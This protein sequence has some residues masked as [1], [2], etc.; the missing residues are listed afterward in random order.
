[1]RASVAKYLRSIFYAS[2]AA[3]A[4]APSIGAAAVFD[5]NS[6]ND[7]PDADVTDGACDTDLATP[8]L[9][10]SL[11]AAIE[12]SNAT[13]GADEIHFAVLT[14]PIA[15]PVTVQ[16]LSAL[17]A[18]TDP[19]DIDGY[20]QFGSSPATPAAPA[21]LNV[22]LDGS[23]VATGVCLSFETNDSRMRGLVVQNCSDVGVLV[24]G[25]RNKFR[26]NYIGTDETGSMAAPN[27]TGMLIGGIA[28]DGTPVGN[29][30]IIGGLEVA[31][32]NLISG[33]DEIGLHVDGADNI[34]RG[35]IIGSDP[36]TTIDLGNGGGASGSLNGGVVV[37]GPNNHI[38]GTAPGALN[39]IS[40]N[41]NGIYLRGN[42][43]GTEVLGNHIGTDLV[44]SSNSI[45][46]RNVDGVFIEGNGNRV[47]SDA[48][49]GGNVISNNVS[50]GI[51]IAGD[52][53]TVEGNYVGLDSTGAVAVPNI[54]SGIL[55][56]G[57]NNRIG[58]Q[59]DGARNVVSGNIGGGIVVSYFLDPLTTFTITPVGNV[60][61]GNYVGL[62][63]TGTLGLG[64][65]DDGILVFNGTMTVIG[66]Q[67]EN[68]G[69]VIADNGGDGVRIEKFGQ[70]IA[71]GNLLLGN[72][73][74]L[75][76]NSVAMGN[77]GSGVYIVGAS[78]N[79]IGG[80]SPGAG[81]TIA[82]NGGDGV[83]VASGVMNAILGNSIF[84]NDLMGIDLDANGTT[85]NDITDPDTGANNLQ[86]YPLLLSATN[87]GGVTAVSGELHSIPNTLVRIELFSSL[88]CDASNH[89]EGNVFLGAYTVTTDAFGDA[90]GA[91]NVSPQVATGSVITATATTLNGISD[92]FNTSEFSECVTVL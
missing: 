4:A 19:V 21:V 87:A 56:H 67:A 9:Q 50:N 12:Q 64:N 6:L 90:L 33:N 60:V 71:G 86:N 38:G 27:G 23:L 2:T 77:G 70:E 85:V 35:N 3:L 68:M 28:T 69:N 22:V 74:G 72:V 58:G 53:N 32:R 63:A 84:L 78:L 37:E 29:E 10:C 46:L 65:G 47:G 15:A 25:D 91:T 44:G 88:T 41:S 81:N 30:N 14:F 42:S 92:M 89:G 45:G 76:A 48:P 40:G 36:T 82:H 62:D 43:A 59:T 11:R 8:F 51:E 5:V 57:S 26:G 66:G 54:S 75:N 55:V 34:I 73:I 17:P 16:P 79:A 18:I 61:S 83:T 20:T 39:V 7:D 52:D 1:M 80:V 24:K 31:K 49:G 13:A